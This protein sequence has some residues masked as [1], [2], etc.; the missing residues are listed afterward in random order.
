MQ[1]LGRG[2]FIRDKDS[3]I[4][5]YVSTSE[6]INNIKLSGGYF[7]G[8]Y[9][10]S[11]SSIEQYDNGMPTEWVY[12]ESSGNKISI[13][14]MLA[15]FDGNVNASPSAIDIQAIN[16]LRIKK[17]R[18]NSTDDW[19]TLYEQPIVVESDFNFSITDYLCR[20]NCDYQYNI[21]PVKNGIETYMD[22]VIDIHSSYDGIYFTNGK[23]QYG[24][25][26]D[27]KSDY[28]RKTSSSTVQPI[29]S[30]YS[31]SIKNGHV[32]YSTGN[33]NARL[34]KMDNCDVDLDG[35][36][37]YRKSAVDFLSENEV[38][39]F[40]NYDG[41]AAIVSIGDEISESFEDVPLAPK[42][43][44]SWEQIGDID[45]YNDLRDNGLIG[46]DNK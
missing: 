24:T 14:T 7:Y 29:N 25:L 15:T 28:N 11:D 45:N 36:Y 41:F 20:N 8:L 23:E 43:S 32:N 4:G 3:F 33:I 46:G 2:S 38:L 44:F 9:A 31:V 10:S 21:I 19:E 17:R 18:K 16:C 37:E 30:R 39:V 1:F 13:T 34:L 5:T 42:I 27:I 6:K 22:N 26:F 12:D 40:K 35:N